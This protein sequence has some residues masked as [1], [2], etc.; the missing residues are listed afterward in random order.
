MQR[1]AELTARVKPENSPARR[2]WS[3]AAPPT[4]LRN[5]AP[6]MTLKAVSSMVSVLVR[7]CI[8]V[9]PMTHASLE[10]LPFNMAAL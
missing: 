5:I 2:L 3:P 8:S 1:L 10:C 6:H 9:T 4:R 7:A